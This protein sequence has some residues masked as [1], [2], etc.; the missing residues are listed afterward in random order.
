MEDFREYLR[1]PPVNYDEQSLGKV[2]NY[3]EKELIRYFDIDKRFMATQAPFAEA[4]ADINVV[5]KKAQV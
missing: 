2:L 5:K 4:N 1:F 3:K